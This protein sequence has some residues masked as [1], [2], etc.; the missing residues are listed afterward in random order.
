MRRVAAVLILAGSTL[1][2][3][4]WRAGSRLHHVFGAAVLLLVAV[5]AL[6]VALAKRL[7]GRR[8]TDRSDTRK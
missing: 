1:G 2:H 6:P 7:L 8:N 5:S 4:F 3:G